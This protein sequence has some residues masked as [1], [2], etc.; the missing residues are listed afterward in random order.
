M[1]PMTDA[2]LRSLVGGA[3]KPGPGRPRR[4]AEA[5]GCA[6]FPAMLA[7]M[8][9]RRTRYA[10]CGRCAQT[11]ATSLML[12][13]AARAATGTALL[14]TSE[15]HRNLPGP[16]FAA[17]LVVFAAKTNPGGSRRAVSGRGDFCGDEER[18]PGVGA[19]SVLPHLTCRIRLNAAPTGRVVSY[20][21]R[22]R[23]DAVRPDMEQSTADCSVPGARR[24]AC[25]RPGRSGVGPK[26][27]PPQHE[28]LPDTAWRD[29]HIDAR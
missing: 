24:G 15:A 19:R 8:A 14:G 3:A 21:A 27:R 9:R 25:K 10:P 16:G 11:A 7:P 13:R 23:G 22:P 12:K 18:S 17:A 1:M 4:F 2:K 29:A 26:G 6:D 28:P 5:V 20:A